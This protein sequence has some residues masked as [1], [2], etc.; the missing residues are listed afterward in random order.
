MLWVGI[1]AR[2]SV[3]FA[4]GRLATKRERQPTYCQRRALNSLCGLRWSVGSSRYSDDVSGHNT[5]GDNVDDMFLDEN[6]K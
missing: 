6:R 5:V 4:S 2:F 1:R 3:G